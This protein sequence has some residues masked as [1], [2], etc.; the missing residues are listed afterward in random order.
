LDFYESDHDFVWHIACKKSATMKRSIFL[1]TMVTIAGLS[2]PL[3]WAQTHPSEDYPGKGGF[4]DSTNGA[5]GSPEQINPSTGTQ[6][7]PSSSQPKQSN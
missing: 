7:T 5:P 1:L 3:A 4:N 6:N 2:S